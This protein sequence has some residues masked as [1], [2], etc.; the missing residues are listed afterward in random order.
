VEE[1][2]KDMLE[3]A[4]NVVKEVQAPG[5]QEDNFPEVKKGGLEWLIKVYGFVMATMYKWRKKRGA[6]GPVLINPIKRGEP[7]IGSPRPNA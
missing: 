3:G 4:C 2:R 5:G 1:F 7:V 6:A